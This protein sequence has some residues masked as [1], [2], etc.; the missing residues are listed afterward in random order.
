M[1]K[2]EASKTTASNSSLALS[3]GA[4]A[5]REMKAN[6]W[7]LQCLQSQ[8]LRFG[9]EISHT[10]GCRRLSRLRTSSSKLHKQRTSIIL[11]SRSAH[12]R[13]NAVSPRKYRHW[14]TRSTPLFD[15]HFIHFRRYCLNRSIHDDA[16]NFWCTYK[17]KNYTFWKI[18]KYWK[19]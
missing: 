14:M 1:W 15:I 9:Y 6:Y 4:C 2:A 19:K 11:L 18:C 10:T 16:L 7:L 13:Y 12:K 5:D 17:K 3:N 8:E